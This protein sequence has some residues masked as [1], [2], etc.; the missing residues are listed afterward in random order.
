MCEGTD[1]ALVYHPVESMTTDVET[2]SHCLEVVHDQTQ[3]DNAGC[4][5]EHENQ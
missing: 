5:N 2:C 3:L 4:Q 1:H